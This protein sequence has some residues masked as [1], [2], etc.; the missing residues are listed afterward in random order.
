MWILFEKINGH[1]DSDSEKNMEVTPQG[2]CFWNN[3]IG[4]I[5]LIPKDNYFFVHKKV[6]ITLGITSRILRENSSYYDVC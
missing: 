5:I 2:R 6:R 3:I 4:P 1:S